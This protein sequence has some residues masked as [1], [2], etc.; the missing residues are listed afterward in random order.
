MYI[1]S[2]PTQGIYLEFDGATYAGYFM[3]LISLLITT[4]A[5]MPHTSFAAAIHYHVK[6]LGKSVNFPLPYK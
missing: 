2:T 3:L 1:L 5:I 4:T 6:P